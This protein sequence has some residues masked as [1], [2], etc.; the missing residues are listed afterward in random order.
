[1]V[2]ERHDQS[3]VL[4]NAER[5]FMQKLIGIYEISELTEEELEVARNLS[6]RFGG[7][8]DKGRGYPRLHA[9]L[10]KAI[11]CSVFNRQFLIDGKRPVRHLTPSRI[12]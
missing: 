9:G 4:N 11:Y 2:I 10:S 5:L 12:R 3:E 6:S 1:M 8:C 7:G